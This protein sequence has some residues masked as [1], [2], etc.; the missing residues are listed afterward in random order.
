VWRVARTVSYNGGKS[1][2]RPG[3]ISGIVRRGPLCAGL[4]CTGGSRDLLDF[5]SATLTPNGRVYYAYASDLGGVR[6]HVAI[7]DLRH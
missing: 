6:T 4:D 5:L 1:F 2:Q 3:T 7:E